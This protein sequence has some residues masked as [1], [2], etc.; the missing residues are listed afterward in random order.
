MRATRQDINNR[1]PKL[2]QPVAATSIPGQ[3]YNGLNEVGP[4][5]SLIPFVDDDPPFYLQKPSSDEGS[6]RAVQAEQLS[7]RPIQSSQLAPLSHSLLSRLELSENDP[8]TFREVI[9][10]LTVENKS[11]KR[12]LKRYKK[13]HNNGLK[14][15]GLFEVR[16]QNLA[17]DKKQELES[18]LQRFASTIHLPQNRSVP[19]SAGVERHRQ[20]HRQ[21]S[22]H[23]PTPSSSPYTKGLDSAYASIS[24][25]AATVQLNSGPSD[26]SI[27]RS[28]KHVLSPLEQDPCTTTNSA[29]QES[30]FHGVPVISD[31]SKQKQVVNKLEALFLTGQGDGRELNKGGV[32]LRPARAGFVNEGPVRL[33]GNH[34]FAEGRVSPQS[35]R[36]TN[37]SPSR[38]E[39]QAAS[40]TIPPESSK[41]PHSPRSLR[42]RS[43]P[44]N[45]RYLR[46]LGVASPVTVSNTRSSH[47]WV[48]LNLL[49]NLAQLHILNVTPEFV[50]QAIQTTSTRLV[51]SEDGRKVR[52]QR[53]LEYNVMSTDEPGDVILTDQHATT[54]PFASE[55][56]PPRTTSPSNRKAPT[57]LHYNSLFSHNKPRPRRSVQESSDGSGNL[58]SSPSDIDQASTNSYRLGDKMDP[59]HGPLMF[60]DR[61]AFFLDLSADPP[62]VDRINHSQY[63]N[64]A[65]E[66]LGQKR[67][68]RKAPQERERKLA[69]R[70]DFS[71]R[72]KSQDW[73]KSPLLHI[74]NRTPT[75]VYENDGSDNR[76][77]L[78]FEASGIGG[79]QLNDNFAI[80]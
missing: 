31:E 9:D 17:S 59:S 54:A 38:H 78:Q 45:L 57:R 71:A 13:I 21:D 15:D 3:W 36:R 23:K 7:S 40:T 49:I 53:D 80:D 73:A 76:K 14:Q 12:Q 44:D 5:A 68:P 60:F 58:S 72:D 25:T 77:I 26:R 19:K 35:G 22:E 43:P 79:I 30:E 10:D 42:A 67:R 52:W 20:I 2:A 50:R 62:D 33:V 34:F 8:N 55:E 74:Y 64:L 16:I 18:I 41:S 24:A 28:R 61:E 27:S 70:S 51:L 75:P 29:L 46:H 65:S 48:Y 63:P 32:D 4:E 56:P 66:P 47:E 39:L 1:H 37:I 6:T 69:I 11:L